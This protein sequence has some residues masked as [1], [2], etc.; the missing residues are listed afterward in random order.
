MD[1]LYWFILIFW[2]LTTII[3]YHYKEKF[4]GLIS[5]LIG[6][7]FGFLLFTNVNFVFGLITIFSGV[8][9]LCTMPFPE[10][11]EKK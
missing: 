5:G 4:F 7:I 11:E 1:E 2:F 10:K 6:I 8:Y 9:L 3:S